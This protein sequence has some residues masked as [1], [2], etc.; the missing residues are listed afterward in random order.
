MWKQRIIDYLDREDRS[1]AWLARR[2]GMDTHYL[3]AI[4]NDLKQP[5]PKVLR[6][7]DRAMG[8]MPGTLMAIRSQPELSTSRE[9]TNGHVV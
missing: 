4:L 6:K 9:A 7:L 3:S 5:G 1:Q 2:A 8:L